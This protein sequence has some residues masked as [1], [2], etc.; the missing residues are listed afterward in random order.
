[1]QTLKKGMQAAGHTP[2]I[3]SGR[4]TGRP[5]EVWLNCEKCE[6]DRKQAELRGTT[7]N[8]S[9]IGHHTPAPS[10]ICRAIVP[11]R[12]ESEGFQFC[13]RWTGCAPQQKNNPAAG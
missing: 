1:M 2:S 9:F 4:T 8:Y 13:G 7:Q 12:G 6:S 3:I 11:A 10:F 5:G